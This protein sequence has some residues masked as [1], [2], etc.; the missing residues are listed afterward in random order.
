MTNNIIALLLKKITSVLTVHY[1]SYIKKQFQLQL[2]L[3]FD[4]WD[5]QKKTVGDSWANIYFL[6][7]NEAFDVSNDSIFVKMYKDCC[8]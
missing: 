1:V 7:L 2:S 4:K 5:F 3:L 8:Y 6:N